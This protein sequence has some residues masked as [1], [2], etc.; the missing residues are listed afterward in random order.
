[1]VDDDTRARFE[2]LCAR[3]RQRAA[4]M[5]NY[6]DTPEQIADQT[7]T[8]EALMASQ[9]ATQ[10]WSTESHT[11]TAPRRA[12]P[13]TGQRTTQR[14]TRTPP[15]GATMPVFREAAAVHRDTQSDD[16]TDD[17]Q[18]QIHDATGLI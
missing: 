15:R 7:A 16:D 2:Q 6:P 12:Q 4:T 8:T 17:Q 3:A 11:M 9:L 1:M 18:R 14:G 5:P 10:A 13:T